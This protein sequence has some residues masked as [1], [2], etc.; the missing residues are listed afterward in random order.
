MRLQGFSD[1]A[2][3]I[4]VYVPYETDR[5]TNMLSQ[6]PSNINIIDTGKFGGSI[7]LMYEKLH[8]LSPFVGAIEFFFICS[9]RQLDPTTWIMVD[10]SYNLFKEIQSGGPSY[11]WK[12]PSGC[13]IQDL[14]NGKSQHPT[15]A[16]PLQSSGL[17]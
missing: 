5:W 17:R 13:V 7:Q 4:S 8:I 15:K 11:S 14:G 3:D 9:C 2:D 10:V 16:Q 6:H 12:F 1:L